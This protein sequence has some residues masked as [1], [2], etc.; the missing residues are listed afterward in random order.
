MSECCCSEQ[1]VLT[2]SPA[3]SASGRVS[4]ADV[5]SAFTPDTEKQISAFT[6]HT[7][8]QDWTASSTFPIEVYSGQCTGRECEAKLGE[9]TLI[10]LAVTRA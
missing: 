6:P 2:P 7:E 10:L 5:T 9:E 3:V 1:P 4:A 8:K